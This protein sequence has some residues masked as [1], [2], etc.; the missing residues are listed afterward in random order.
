MLFFVDFFLSSFCFVLFQFLL[1]PLSRF[2][3]S[4]I[5]DSK[6]RETR[7]KHDKMYAT[8]AAKKQLRQN[9]LYP[10]VLE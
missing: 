8:Y 9:E 1:F 4:Q 10:Q 5:I 6:R 7:P 2:L 3:L